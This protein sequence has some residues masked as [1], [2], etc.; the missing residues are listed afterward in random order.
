ML[1]RESRAAAPNRSEHLL[2]E[3]GVDTIDP[4]YFAQNVFELLRAEATEPFQN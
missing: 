4:A 2:A 3:L 1:G